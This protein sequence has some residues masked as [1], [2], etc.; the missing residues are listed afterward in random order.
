M[1]TTKGSSGTVFLGQVCVYVCLYVYTAKMH[2]YIIKGSSGTVLLDQVSLHVY[3]CILL[4]KRL[5][6]HRVYVYVYACVCVCMYM[7][8]KYMFAAQSSLFVCVGWLHW[9]GCVY[10]CVCVRWW[11][12]GCACV[13]VRVCAALST[14]AR[15]VCTCICVNMYACMY[16]YTYT[17]A[18]SM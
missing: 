16:T 18:R 14:S 3:T 15:C 12:D 11:V 1:Y 2:V 10:V 4:S 9:C 6:T 13:Y 5:Q 8:K 17:S 7:A